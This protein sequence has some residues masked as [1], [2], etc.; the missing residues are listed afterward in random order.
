MDFDRESEFERIMEEIFPVSIPAQFV[1]SLVVKLKN[2]GTVVLKGDELLQ[3]LPISNDL[4]WDKLVEQFDS[5]EDIEV[6]ID[7]PAIQNNV[8]FN[9]KQILSAHFKDKKGKHDE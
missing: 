6:F 5:I 7:M 4:S 3:P 8:A 2:G 1:K 9:V